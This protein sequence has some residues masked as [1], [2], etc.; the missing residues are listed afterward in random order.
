[1]HAKEWRTRVASASSEPD[2]RCKEKKL[3]DEQRP[4]GEPPA[5]SGAGGVNAALSEAVVRVMREYV[6][7]GPTRARTSVRDD[8]VVVVLGETL[9]KAERSLADDGK[10]ERVLRLRQDF[11]RTMRKDLTAAV[12]EITGRRVIAFMSDNHIDPDL[13][14][15]VFVLEPSEVEVPG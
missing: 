12:E 14:C 15:E 2:L 13:A 9:T 6:G 5:Q 11:Q 3:L 4:V 8:V 7:R 1:M 10:Q